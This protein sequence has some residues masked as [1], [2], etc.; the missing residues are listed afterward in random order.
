MERGRAADGALIDKD[1]VVDLAVADDVV[2]RQRLVAVFAFAAA[3][4][5]VQR[6]LHERAFARAADAGDQAQH[7]ERKLDGDVFQIVAARTEQLDPAAIGAAG[8][9]RESKCRGGRPGI[10]RS[11]WRWAASISSSV[12]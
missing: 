10:R 6:V 12:P 2:V 5:A 1:D 11:G 3:E 7:A 9:F 4:R 8:G